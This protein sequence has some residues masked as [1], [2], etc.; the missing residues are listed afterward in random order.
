MTAWIYLRMMFISSSDS[1]KEEW[2]SQSLPLALD[3]FERSSALQLIDCA[4]FTTSSRLTLDCISNRALRRLRSRAVFHRFVL[5]ESA[6]I[7]R[8]YNRCGT[9]ENRAWAEGRNDKRR[10]ITP[11]RLLVSSDHSSKIVPHRQHEFDWWQE[12]GRGSLQDNRECKKRELA[13]RCFS[14]GPPHAPPSQNMAS[15]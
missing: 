10:L 1:A 11:H 5:P 9:L 8:S 14:F 15:S 4:G 2:F 12:Q 3:L 6:P 7:F 13:T